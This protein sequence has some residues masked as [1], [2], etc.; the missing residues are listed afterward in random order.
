MLGQL[1][2]LMVRRKGAPA[3]RTQACLRARART[4]TTARPECAR[5]ALL[6]G[7]LGLGRHG[8][9]F[10]SSPLAQVC[11]WLWVD[12]NTIGIITDTAVFHWSM[13]G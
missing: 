11:L 5:S 9:F 3:H 7:E 8:R 10:S 4:R 6:K 1:C 13:E 12:E 2:A